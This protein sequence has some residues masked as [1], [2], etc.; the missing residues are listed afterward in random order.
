MR[1]CG[2]LPH[3]P[4]HGIMWSGE[5]SHPRGQMTDLVPDCVHESQTVSTSCPQISSLLIGLPVFTFS[6]FYQFRAQD[7]NSSVALG[8]VGKIDSP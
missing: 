7:L 3:L 4:Y 5:N 6:N 1:L 2:P 8:I